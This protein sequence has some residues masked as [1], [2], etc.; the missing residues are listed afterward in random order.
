MIGVFVA[1]TLLAVSIRQYSSDM[2]ADLRRD[3]STSLCMTIKL[4]H[5]DSSEIGT[6]L[7]CPGLTFGRLTYG[8]IKHHNCHILLI[9]SVCR[10]ASYIAYRLDSTADCY[11][12]LEQLALLLMS[13]GCINDD[14]I[15]T[16][17]SISFALH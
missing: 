6:I 5:D 13:T 11:H 3:S 10:S 15:E 8:R 1:A 2:T 7:E 16:L 4:R 17:W 14:Y 9:S 12:L